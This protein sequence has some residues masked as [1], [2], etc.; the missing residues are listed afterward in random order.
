MFNLQTKPIPNE[1]AIGLH[2]DAINRCFSKNTLAE[3]RLPAQFLTPSYPEQIF[4]ALEKEN[5]DWSK[6]VLERLRLASPLM[7]HV[8]FRLQRMGRYLNTLEEALQLEYRIAQ[9]MIVRPHHLY[10]PPTPP[11]LPLGPDY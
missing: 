5:T 11:P 8:T 9:H 6:G 2:Q 3:V 1:T 7:L 10:L 4:E